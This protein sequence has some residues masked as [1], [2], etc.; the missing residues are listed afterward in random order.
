MKTGVHVKEQDPSNDTGIETDGSLGRTL[1]QVGRVS[2]TI[3]RS[4]KDHRVD[5]SQK[6]EFGSF[7][8]AFPLL[9]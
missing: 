5:H 2:A 1:T 7:I 6:E 8:A 9:L 3:S 4:H